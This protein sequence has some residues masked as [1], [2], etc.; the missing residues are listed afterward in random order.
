MT[1]V[2]GYTPETSLQRAQA[3]AKLTQPGADAL[4]HTRAAENAFDETFGASPTLARLD[5]EAARPTT[6]TS[7]AE[8]VGIFAALTPL[9][10]SR[11]TGAASEAFELSTEG[12]LPQALPL[13]ELRDAFKQAGARKLAPALAR[14]NDTILARDLAGLQARLARH[15]TTALALTPQVMAQIKQQ[16]VAPLARH[17][18]SLI[19]SAVSGD[20]A[21]T[22]PLLVA[23]APGG[24]QS[25]AAVAPG[26]VPPEYSVLARA[27][28]ARAGTQA[29][30]NATDI[31]QLV[32]QVIL[33]CGQDSEL[34]LRKIANEMQ[35][36]IDKSAALRKLQEQQNQDAAQ[37]RAK[38]DQ[39]YQSLVHE[40]A[41]DPKNCSQE[42]YEAWRPVAVA[43]PVIDDTT[44]P[45]TIDYTKPDLAQPDPVNAS[46]LPA[47]F[48]PSAPVAPPPAALS[49]ETP[50]AGAGARAASATFRGAKEREVESA[51]LAPAAAKQLFHSPATSEQP[52]G[53]TA[54]AAETSGAAQTFGATQRFGATERFGAAETSGA[55]STGVPLETGSS[56]R[57]FTDTA[58]NVVTTHA[59]DLALWASKTGDLL[60]NQSDV[61]QQMQLKI[62]IA[63]Q[64]YAQCMQMV[65]NI[66]KSSSDSK[67][68]IIKNLTN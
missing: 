12:P 8:Q 41:I 6:Q 39:E 30:G 43:D 2:S 23:Q 22:A 10:G 68:G 5:T 49:G 19:A 21:A 3:T 31:D 59:S 40:G 62:Q 38:V 24:A 60:Q 11:P 54:T 64:A 35:T 25:S 48:A 57:Q 26:T 4:R 63:Q 37:A 50:A 44:S 34:D 15:G 42:Q 58:G 52:H 27:I 66:L 13:E 29:L 46:D 16:L 17:V 61:T 20:T 45:P 56:A 53:L 36:H 1:K 65:S 32:E 55:L 47:S 14:L 28:A 51:A 33:E 18:R 7:F 67:D 9:I